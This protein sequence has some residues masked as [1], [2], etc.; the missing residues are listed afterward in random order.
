M[1]LDKENKMR[2]TFK[3]TIQAFLY[4]LLV[5]S[6]LYS[7]GMSLVSGNITKGVIGGLFFGIFLSVFLSFFLFVG[8]ILF[9]KKLFYY[10][11]MP[12]LL[13]SKK[14]YFEGVA[15][16]ATSGRIKYGGL[17]LTEDSVLFIPHRFAIG[18][19]IVDLPLERIRNVNRVG[20]SL[21]KS[22]SGGLRGRL[23]LETKNG[24]RYEFSV[25]EIDKWM[26][27]INERLTPS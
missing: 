2:N 22:F 18:P 3:I 7:I 17:F 6:S 21:L 23:L 8:L 11:N 9:K 14:V 13:Q 19:K 20:I 24:E 15:G 26:K 12:R 27:D 4:F 25:W 5:G 16:N 10:S 1:S